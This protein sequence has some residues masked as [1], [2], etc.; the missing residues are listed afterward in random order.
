MYALLQ[1]RPALLLCAWQNVWSSRVRCWSAILREERRNHLEVRYIFL[2]KA[3][4]LHFVPLTW[5]LIEVRCIS[6]QDH[7]LK[8][9]ELRTKSFLKSSLLQLQPT[10]C[11]TWYSVALATVPLTFMSLCIIFLAGVY[12]LEDR[13][14]VSP[15]FSLSVYPSA[16]PAFSKGPGCI[17]WSSFSVKNQ[18]RE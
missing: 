12:T 4:V 14:R 5:G 2:A 13:S 1:P 10:S 16:S 3:P 17:P 15:T 11:L 7:G 6:K 9:I 18:I 8:S